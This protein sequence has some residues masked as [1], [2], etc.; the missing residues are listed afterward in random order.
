HDA[1]VHELEQRARL[2]LVR[3]TA[4]VKHLQRDAFVPLAISRAIDRAHAA[5]ACEPFDLEPAKNHVAGLQRHAG[6]GLI[7]ARRAGMTIATS[8]PLPTSLRMSTC[9]PIALIKP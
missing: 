2:R 8:V 1:R 3:A 5:F 6:G 9:P 4:R 7:D